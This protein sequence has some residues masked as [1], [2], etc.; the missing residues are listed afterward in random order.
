MIL[1]LLSC[2][3][4]NRSKHFNRFHSPAALRVTLLGLLAPSMTMRSIQELVVNWA[5]GARLLWTKQRHDG[6]GRYYD[7]Q[8][9]SFYTFDV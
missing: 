5:S 7:V 1:N 6:H 8:T 4:R 2:L 3:L 9:V